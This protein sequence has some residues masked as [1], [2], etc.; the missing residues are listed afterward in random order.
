MSAARNPFRSE[1]MISLP[2]LPQGTSW[3]ALLLDL[4]A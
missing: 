3:Q 4:E 1:A 2:F